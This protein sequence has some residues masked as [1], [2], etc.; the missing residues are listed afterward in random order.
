[1]FWYAMFIFG[2]AIVVY[3]TRLFISYAPNK[4]IA[5]LIYLLLIL[6]SLVILLDKLL[7][8]TTGFYIIPHL[9]INSIFVVAIIVYSFFK[10]EKIEDVDL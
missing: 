5:A 9:L 7:D 3:V 6:V 2:A 8:T 1:M 10:R 4:R